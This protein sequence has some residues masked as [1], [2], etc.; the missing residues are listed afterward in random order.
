MIVRVFVDTNVIVYAR[1][2]A[3]AAKRTAAIEWLAAL[4]GRDAAVVSP[5]VLNES[6][7]AFIEKMDASAAELR[8]FVTE[9]A[10]WCTASIEPQVVAHAIDIRDR[11]RFAWWDSLIVSS[12]LA[13]GCRYLLTEDFQDGQEIGDLTVISPF[14]HTPA[15]LL[16]KD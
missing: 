6:I 8:R 12:A 1:D 4:A 3:E 5:Q 14:E 9:I 2:R 15:T 13:A 10:P 11:W 7:R 16:P